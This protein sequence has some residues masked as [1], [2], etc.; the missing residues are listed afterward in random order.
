[1]LYTVSNK[2]IKLNSLND[3]SFIGEIELP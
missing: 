1:V 3:L 2:R